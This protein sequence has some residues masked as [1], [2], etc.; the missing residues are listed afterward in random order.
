MSQVVKIEEAELPL[1]GLKRAVSIIEEGGIVAFPTESFYG[2]GVDA[3]NSSAIQ[4]IFRVKK[5][6][7]GLPLLILIS[8]IDEL[9][10]Y[11]AS[12][13]PEALELGRRF[14]PGGL[15][16]VLQRSQAIPSLLTAGTGKIGIRVSGHPLAHALTLEL[17][18][19][20]TGTS[21]NISG[22][23][24]C[25]RADE[26]VECFGGQV[27]LILDGGITKGTHPSTLLDVTSNPPLLI[28]EGII[29]AE[30]IIDSGIYREILVSTQ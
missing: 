17:N 2:L 14:W 29:K 7:P 4:R 15:T 6:D 1:K 26:V 18:V 22:R 23:P 30:E 8:S 20:V 12:I 24:P 19:P 16:M 27:D 9:S 5:R 21:A 28:R 25:T 3:T 11:T 10:K 13:P